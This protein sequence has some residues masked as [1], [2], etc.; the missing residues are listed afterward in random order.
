MS[1]WEKIKQT[2]RS[3]MNGRYGADELGRTMLWAGLA[4]YFIGAV[5]QS[6][7][8][9]LLGFAVY[10]WIIFRM[11]SRN[12]EKRQAE[13]R[14]FLS[15][16]TQT[17]TK[18]KQARARFRNRKQYKYFKCPNCKSWLRLPHGTGEVNVTCSRCHTSFTKKA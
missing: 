13:N 10:V 12:T 17:V 8:V 5:V 18:W 9:M 15:W 6:G 14:R 7:L 16:K 3:F 11:F 2:F 4:V 1:F